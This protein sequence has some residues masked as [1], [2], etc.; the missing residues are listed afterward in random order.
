M[1]GTWVRPGG[2]VVE[3]AFASAFGIH[4]G[5]SLRLGG[6]AFRVV[7]T[8][9]TAAILPIRAPAADPSVA[10]WW[11]HRFLQPGLVWATEAD[12]KQLAEAPD[13]RPTS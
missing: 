8:A 5:D 6:T 10:S 9:V 1:Q 2:V 7:G 12:A 4:V 13:P 3:A 11:E